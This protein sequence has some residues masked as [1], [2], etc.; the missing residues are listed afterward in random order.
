MADECTK[1]VND[2]LQSLDQVISNMKQNTKDDAD[3]FLY[4]DG[5]DENNVYKIMQ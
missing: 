4:Q 1:L 3:N 5:E 2:C